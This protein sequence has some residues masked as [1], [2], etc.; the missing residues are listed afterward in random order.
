LSDDWSQVYRSVYPDLVR[1]LYRKVWDAERAADLAQECFVR[2]L[3]ERPERPRPWL[4][5]V[6]ANLARD[7]ARTVIRRKQHLTLLAGDEA[8]RT[9]PD[10]P[11]TELADREER[12]KVRQALSR[13]GDGDREVLLLW[14]AGLNYQE[15]AAETGRAVGAI[16]T[17]LARARKRL[18]EAYHAEEGDH[19]ARG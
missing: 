19:V 12:E 6:A 1:F 7:E 15:I 16:G 18:L 13:L 9:A 17:T 2:G 3:R 14:D 8:G 5:T 10:D 11:S 4:F